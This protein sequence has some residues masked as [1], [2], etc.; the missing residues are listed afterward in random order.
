MKKPGTTHEGR[1]ATGVSKDAAREPRV[2]RPRILDRRLIF[3]WSTRAVSVALFLSVAYGAS[4]G[5]TSGSGGRTGGSAGSTAAGGAGGMSELAGS[6]GATVS[7]AAVGCGAP[8]LCS[9]GCHETCGCCPCASGETNGNLICTDQGCFGPPPTANDGGADGAPLASCDGIASEYANALAKAKECHANQPNQCAAQ[10]RAGF[11]CNC[12]TWVNGGEVTLMNI[13]SRYVAAGCQT[14]CIGTCVQQQPATCTA[15]ATSSSGWRCL[16]PNVLS[17]TDADNGRSLTVPVGEE[18]DLTLQTIGPNGYGTQ[19][20]VSSAAVTVLEV[21]IAAGPP[22]PGGPI[23]FYRLQATSLGTATV[24]IPYVVAVGAAVS[25]P[26]PP[27]VLTI[28]VTGAA[29]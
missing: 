5:C 1:T 15:D 26:S 17:L 8:P 11:F 18:I 2:W 16:P 27:F 9:E 4:P 29:P 12:Q 23:R 20:D 25:A 13:A 7:C 14:V 28:T 6:G 3:P 24:T 22:N 10:V 21:T 19:V